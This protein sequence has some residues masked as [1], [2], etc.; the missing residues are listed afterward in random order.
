MAEG[1]IQARKV[2]FFV[3]KKDMRDKPSGTQK[4]LPEECYSSGLLPVSEYIFLTNATWKYEE[5][6]WK[7]YT[8]F[9]VDEYYV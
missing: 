6:V 9:L 4:K 5:I 1:C 7:N 8:S 2:C 3:I